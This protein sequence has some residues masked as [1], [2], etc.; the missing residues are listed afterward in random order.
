[1]TGKQRPKTGPER[2]RGKRDGERVIRFVHGGLG[3]SVAQMQV[4]ACEP[5][6]VE[7][8][9]EAAPTGPNQYHQLKLE[10]QRR[11]ECTYLVAWDGD[12]P[13]GHG[14]V[15]W[16]G[17]NAEE[18]RSAY[19][20]CPEINGLLVYQLRGR[21]IGTALIRAAEDL[22]RSRGCEL[23]GIGADDDNLR[24]RTLYERLGYQSGIKYV[25]VWSHIDDAGRTR[26]MR[27]PGTFLVKQL[28][29]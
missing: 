6:D 1:M 10:R 15:K 23:I 18:V 16:D 8:L 5:G 13:L 3:C 20:N 21:G 2:G 27:D 4:R 22:A 24:A 7:A 25:D 19:P 12:A 14:E 9:E 11:G 26:V 17:C 28:T 29:D